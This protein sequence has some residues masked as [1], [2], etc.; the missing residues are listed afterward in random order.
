VF[1]RRVLERE[2][3]R[4][5]EH[6]N[7][8]AA[9]NTPLWSLANGDIPAATV[10][11]A[12]PPDVAFGP[13]VGNADNAKVVVG[14]TWGPILNI[15][16]CAVGPGAVAFSLRPTCVNGPTLTMPG[17]CPGELLILG[18]VFASM[19]VAHGGVTCNIP[20]QPVPAS[21]LGLSWACQGFVRTATGSE[22]SSVIYG[23]VDVCF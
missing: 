6:Y 11:L 18:V 2:T 3:E 17:G 22:L 12:C 5:A 1:L 10:G 20:N 21:A 9:V 14:S 4:A 23:V 16:T 7:G 15:G 8:N 13:L 19:V